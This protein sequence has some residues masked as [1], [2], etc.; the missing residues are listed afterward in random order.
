MSLSEKGRIR[1]RRGGGGR[2][3]PEPEQR[4][5]MVGG[6]WSW[7]R[8]FQ[9]GLIIPVCKLNEMHGNLSEGTSEP[10]RNKL[11]IARMPSVTFPDV[12]DFSLG[13]HLIGLLRFPSLSSEPIF[14]R[15]EV[16]ERPRGDYA[17]GYICLPYTSGT[18]RMPCPTRSV[19][20]RS[21]VN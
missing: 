5:Y 4:R 16:T 3:E 2:V 14:S 1:R 19:R 11:Q 7:F 12:L 9:S 15:T 18:V 20:I 8:K 21:G 13:I 10:E 6:E 17:Q